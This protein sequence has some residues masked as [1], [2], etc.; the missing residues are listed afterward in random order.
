M[1]DDV[2]IRDAHLDD[3]PVLQTIEVIAGRLFID[4]AMPEIAGDEPLPLPQLERYQ[5][6]GLA[7]V[8]ADT[9]DHPIAYLVAEEVDGNLHIEQVSV[10]PNHARQGIGRRLI[11]RTAQEARARKLPA[12]TLTT[13]RDVP[14]NAA[15]YHRCGFEIIDPSDQSPGLRRIRKHEAEQGLD[16][17]PRVCMRKVLR[18]D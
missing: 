14:W 1:M 18:S 13:F 12:L 2:L 11:E 15:Y 6:S 17:W 5:Q 8:A 4:V 3:L 10:H 16:R 9:K 7:W